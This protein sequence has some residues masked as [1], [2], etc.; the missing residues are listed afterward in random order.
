MANEESISS[1][2]AGEATFLSEE[3]FFKT[4]DFE[5]EESVGQFGLLK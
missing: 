4:I 2:V 5:E 1:S 3:N